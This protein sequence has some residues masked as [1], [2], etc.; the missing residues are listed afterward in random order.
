MEVI[1]LQ[2]RNLF[3]YNARQQDGRTRRTVLTI[4]DRENKPLISFN[5]EE[6]EELKKQMPKIKEHF[7]RYQKKL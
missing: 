3:V 6:Y 4:A 5:E 2:K 7:V 1:P